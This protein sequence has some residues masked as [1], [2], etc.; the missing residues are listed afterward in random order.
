MENKTLYFLRH[1]QSVYNKIGIIQGDLDSPL[2]PEGRKD[3]E[4]HSLFFT[5]LNLKHIAHSSL[6]RAYKTAEIINEKLD[7]PTSEWDDLKE[8]DFG[9]WECEMK[10][11]NWDQFRTDFYQHGKPPP[12]GES[13]RQ[14]FE[15]A[16]KE[17]LNICT[18]ISDDPVLIVC[19]GMIMRILL[20]VWF[21]NS[22]EKEMRAIEMPNL[23]LY[24]VDV[25][26]DA[27]EIRPT[28]YEFI[29]VNK[30]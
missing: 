7:L 24:K 21:T 13:K 11:E 17:V 10:F 14:V 1:G 27:K 4:K 12:G 23:A 8:M 2:S 6:S 26:F 28:G 22:T 29:D 20:G 30:S 18:E 19:H 3:V 16:K 5:K 15:R 25:K 9:K